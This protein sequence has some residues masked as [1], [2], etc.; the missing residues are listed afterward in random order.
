MGEF[1]N[2]NDKKETYSGSKKES[3]ENDRKENDG[4]EDEN[5]KAQ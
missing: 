2:F 1:C 4:E 5:T 3:K